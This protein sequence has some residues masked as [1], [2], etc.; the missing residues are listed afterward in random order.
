MPPF[1]T[2]KRGTGCSLLEGCVQW[3]A[4]AAARY[5]AKGYWK[6]ETLGA[7][8]RRWAAGRPDSAAVIAGE[9]QLTYRDLDRHAD[10]L[11]MHLGRLGLRDR[12]RILVQLTNSPQFFPLIFAC[13]RTGVIPIMTLPAHRESEMA[14][15]AS[16]S[17]ALAYVVPGSGRFDYVALVRTVCQRVSSIQRGIVDHEDT[18]ELS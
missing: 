15:F 1:S 10:S 2:E 16:L 5:R 11:A 7:H 8:L 9:E 14:H 12:D 13:F 3:P 18:S 4:D 6:G 17:G